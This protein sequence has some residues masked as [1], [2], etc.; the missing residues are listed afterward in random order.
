MNPSPTNHTVT[1]ALLWFITAQG[2]H[3]LITPMRHPD[4]G[5]L[6]TTLVSMQ[7]LVCLAG[8]VWLW[9][10]GRLKKSAPPAR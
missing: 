3:W 1:A 4:A 10:T 5:T 8:I 6:R 7:V 2:G 9:R